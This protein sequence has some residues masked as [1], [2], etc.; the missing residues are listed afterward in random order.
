MN[1]LKQGIFACF[2]LF[3]VSAASIQALDLT[4][5]GPPGSLLTMEDGR[6]A[7]LDQAGNYIVHDLNPGDLVVFSTDI[8]GYY[9]G[10]YAVEI[11]ELS[12][13]YRIAPDP[14]GIA[15]IELKLTDSGFCPALGTELYFKPENSYISIDLY[16]SFI[17]LSPLFT[18]TPED[19]STR[20]VMPMLGAGF[21]ILPFDSLVRINLGASVGGVFGSELPHPLFAAEASAGIEFKFLDHY[22]LFAEINPR[23]LMPIS[24]GWDDYTDIFG[25]SRAAYMNALGS[26]RMFG[27]P[28]T[29]F[30]FKYK[31]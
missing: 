30:G 19:L 7:K 18:G 27:F 31:Y 3:L 23:L 2:I 11:G 15:A 4:I 22:I 6:T 28:S 8:P 16:Q 29:W 26:W 1:R 12:K 21:Y 20:Y 13:T 9:P 5:I 14:T 25:S 17:A 24:G 10:D